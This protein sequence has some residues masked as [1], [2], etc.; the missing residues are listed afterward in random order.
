MQYPYPKHHVANEYGNVSLV[1]YVQYVVN[2]I[3]NKSV[4]PYGDFGGPVVYWFQTVNN[5]LGNIV[6]TTFDRATNVALASYTV[7]YGAA[8]TIG[9]VIYEPYPKSQI[10]T[11]FTILPQIAT[12][13]G[14]VTP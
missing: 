3:N 9:Q 10:A 1:A 5:G 6:Y 13:N 7:R 14:T 12:Y 8:S 4:V 11:Q 2:A